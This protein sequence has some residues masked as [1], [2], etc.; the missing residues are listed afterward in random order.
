MCLALPVAA[1]VSGQLGVIEPV[2]DIKD[3]IEPSNP[4]LMK[5]LAF[6][7]TSARS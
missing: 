3:D 5:F 1:P 6:T 4:A 7:R 2:D